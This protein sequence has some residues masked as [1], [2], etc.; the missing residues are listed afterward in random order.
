MM[1]KQAAGRRRS[2]LVFLVALAVLAAL[3]LFYIIGLCVPFVRLAPT[4]A[5]TADLSRY[6]A[7][8]EGNERVTLIDG[9]VEALDW[10]LRLIREAKS[11]ILLSTY[12]FKAGGAADLLGA[13]FLAAADRG[14]RVRI[15]VDGISGVMNMEN[16]LYFEALSAHPNIELRIY[17]RLNV[18]LPW[19]LSG[20][21]HDK[22]FVVDDM[23]YIVGGR[24]TC[25][26]F[27][28]DFGAKDESIDREL[29]VLNVDPLAEYASVHELSAYFE[30][31]WSSEAVTAFRD[32]ARS[33]GD[34]E[35]RAEWA[36][37]QKK[38]AASPMPLDVDDFTAW[39]TENTMPTDRISLITGEIG[40][41]GK[42][43]IVWSE[44]K[45][46]MLTAKERVVLQTP[47]IVCSPDMYRDLADIAG[48]APTEIITNSVVNTDNWFTPPDYIYHQDEILDTGVSI[49]EL[50][51]ARSTH[52]KT[53]LIDDSLVL[54]GSYNL[55]L[56][57]T[58]V[59]TELMVAIDSEALG[60]EI[61]GSF[62][63]QAESGSTLVGQGTL[64]RDRLAEVALPKRIL[65]Y[66]VGVLV[67]P[68]RFEL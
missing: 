54:I 42:D 45:Q 11:E 14:V 37:M 40:I 23:A 18:L 47:Y 58:Y 6:T 46:L 53:V 30:R 49:R 68:F 27:L 33:P 50:D 25:D 15:L 21:L 62:E 39:A 1:R 41:Y 3:I 59:S 13:A 20:R 48:N 67:Q 34:A 32:G 44:M 51:G 16:E 66:I 5:E 17:N 55:D 43:P 36:R 29:L 63:R 22:M 26:R 12:Q 65:W 8:A 57:S 35:V 2:D 4:R 52:A 24:N 28:G 60:E 10:R 31:L 38:L 64:V 9:N 7:D 61:R 19:K 56:R